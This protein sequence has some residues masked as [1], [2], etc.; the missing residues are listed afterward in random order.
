M[1]ILD[2]KSIFFDLDHTL[3]DF[4]KN[5]EETLAELFVTYRF[6]RL[7]M[8]SADVFIETYTRNNHRL[9]AKYH[10]GEIDKAEL[11]KARFADTFTELGV[12]P[13]LFPLQFEVDYLHICPRKTNLFPHTHEVL[14]YLQGKYSLHLISN[15]FKEASRIKIANSGLANY[16]Q[17][18]VISELVGVHKPHP[19]IFHHAVANAQ[20]HIPES[21]MIGDSIEAD[22]RGAQGVGMD[23]VFFNPHNQALPEDIKRSITGLNEL[24]KLL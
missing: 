22:I 23:A 20:T 1:Q 11:R 12:D 3:W 13:A 10:I 16:F 7:G 21:V 17:T 15:G 19:E 4:D 9:W 2:K 24:T 6:D 18:V 14:E 5:A 8:H